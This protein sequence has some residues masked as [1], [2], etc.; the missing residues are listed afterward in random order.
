MASCVTITVPHG[1][2][3]PVLEATEFASLPPRRQKHAIQPETQVEGHT[4]GFHA[5]SSIYK[6]YGMDPEAWKLRFRLGTDQPTVPGTDTTGTLQPDM[7]RV[8]RQ[9]G[10][11]V[12]GAKTIEAERIRRHLE[13]GH[14]AVAVV[15]RS[16]MHWIVLA[17]LDGDELTVVDSM[18][19]EPIYTPFDTFRRKAKNILLISPGVATNAVGA[20]HLEGIG[21][22][23]NTIRPNKA[24]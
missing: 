22:M 4:C 14:S 24:Q 6:S 23:L 17:G 1:K 12:S 10:F 2:Y 5:L 11:E 8:L 9:D 18:E 19:P 3:N 16:V 20:S 15:Q 21:E 7:M 13:A